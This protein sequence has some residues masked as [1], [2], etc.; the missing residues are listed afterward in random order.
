MISND[1]GIRGGAGGREEE[2]T[3]GGGFDD[4]IRY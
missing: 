2:G 1:E 3:S 4:A